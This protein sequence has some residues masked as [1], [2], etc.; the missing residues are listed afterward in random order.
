MLL[1]DAQRLEAATE[2]VE[3]VEDLVVEEME[4]IARLKQEN[5]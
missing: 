2:L 5:A 1:T 4:E 3:L